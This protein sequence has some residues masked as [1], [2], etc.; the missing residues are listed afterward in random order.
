M[1][2]DKLIE[3]IKAKRNHSVVGLDTRI[4]F[5]PQDIR[6]KYYNKYSD[7]VKSETYA[8]LEFNKIVIDTIK[9]IVP[10]VKPQIA[11]YESYGIEGLYVFKETVN[12]AKEKGLIIIADVKRGDIGSTAKGYARAYFGG[13]FVEV[14]SITV[15]PYLG[16]DSIIPF[17]EYCHSDKGI[18]VLAKTSNKSSVDIQD[19]TIENKKVYEIMAEYIST[20][21]KD[22][23]GKYGYSSVGAVVGATYPEVMKE[24]R[25]IMPKAYFLVPGYGAQGGTAKDV[26]DCFNEDGLGAVINSSRGI[27]GAHMKDEYKEKYDEKDFYLAIKDA[28]IKMRDEINLELNKAG[29]LLF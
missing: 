15:N 27:I 21:G 29:K 11:F 5:V 13:G 4:D 2:T 1:F 17:L 6:E 20:W 24:L 8:I 23:K 25:K 22:Y 7:K 3:K 26:V 14:N 10:I 28:A 19:L 18:F 12:Y 9:D 16:R